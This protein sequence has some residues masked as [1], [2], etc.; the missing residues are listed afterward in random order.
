MAGSAAVAEPLGI[1][2]ARRDHE[3]L[4]GNE[5]GSSSTDEL[6]PSLLRAVACVKVGL[7]SVRF[8]PV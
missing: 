1:Q 2:D 7:T 8:T 5:S 4:R 3:V 6:V